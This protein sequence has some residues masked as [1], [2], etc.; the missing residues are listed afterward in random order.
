MNRK[1]RRG[2]ATVETVVTM[3]AL[4]P[5]IFYAL[6][7]E[8]L[9]YYKME[10]QEPTIV[11]GW[12]FTVPGNIDSDGSNI[13]GLNRLKYCDHEAAFDSFDQPYDCDDGTHHKA[14]A[15]H[16]CWIIPGADQ[17]RCNEGSDGLQSNVGTQFFGSTK[18]SGFY[19]SFYGQAGKSAVGMNVCTAHLGVMNYFLPQKMIGF[20]KDATDKTR[21]DDGQMFK[22]S[23]MD[24]HGDQQ[25]GRATSAN[26]WI[27]TMEK[28]AILNGGFGLLDVEKVTPDPG[29]ADMI[30]NSIG[31]MGG[32]GNQISN[33]SNQMNQ[34]S[35]SMGGQSGMQ[36]YGN[37]AQHHDFDDDGNLGSF[38]NTGGVGGMQNAGQNMSNS[39][40]NVG[41]SI[42][43]L[44]QSLFGGGNI[45]QVRS[46]YYYKQYGQDAIEKAGKY[47]DD[48][49]D[50]LS[51]GTFPPGA[52]KDGLALG[53]AGAIGGDNIG[54][55][56]VY[57]DPGDTTRA[58][59]GGKASGGED[60]RQG[61]DPRTDGKYPW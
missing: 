31:N 28:Y 45:L 49:K 33:M 8:D 11:A 5:I 34:I 15:A 48:M 23:Q 55:L 53:G 52:N 40:Q 24:A 41:N 36:N 7:L 39:L 46:E 54:T 25:S 27:L 56:P 44:G 38:G 26:T 18:A 12:D 60:D 4:L 32:M 37:E 14:M 29:I 22:D 43:N 17:V 58:N 19:S 59:Q 51:D 61:Q 2:A 3:I 6:F 57:Y 47:A 50:Y 30:G 35:N 1:H 20:G 13:G 9:V 21:L 16:Q 42:G 10:N